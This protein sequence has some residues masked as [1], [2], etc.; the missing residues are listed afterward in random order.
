VLTASRP[1]PE[2]E[3]PERAWR[4]GGGL[5]CLNQHAAGMAT[6]LLGDPP[7]IGWC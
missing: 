1:D 3:G 4:S 7:V 6:T 2:E 5:G